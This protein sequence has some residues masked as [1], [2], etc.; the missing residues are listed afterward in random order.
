ML[1]KSTISTKPFADNKNTNA[2]FCNLISR[3]HVS[4]RFVYCSVG[5]R[6][7]K[8]AHSL[9]VLCYLQ[10]ECKRIFLKPCAFWSLFRTHFTLKRV[11]F[12]HSVWEVIYTITALCT[13]LHYEVLF[14]STS[15]KA[16]RC[17]IYPPH[18]CIM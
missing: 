8:F 13:I 5:M 14:W 9:L 11:T 10:K 7:N 18:I 2:Y 1:Q 12:P 6:L 3:Y 17:K 16:S 4:I 15:L